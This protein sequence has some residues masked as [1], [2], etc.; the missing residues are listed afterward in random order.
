MANDESPSQLIISN[1]DA[2]DG[3]AAV[4]DSVG[5]VLVANSDSIVFVPV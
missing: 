5:S 1:D 4:E 2:I 3:A